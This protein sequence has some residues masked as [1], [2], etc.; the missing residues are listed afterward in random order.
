MQIIL[1]D[2]SELPNEELTAVK[3]P[4]LSRQF[5]S[6]KIYSHYRGFRVSAALCHRC[7]PQLLFWHVLKHKDSYLLAPS[8]DP[9][10]ETSLEP[11]LE[12]GTSG[13]RIWADMFEDWL[14]RGVRR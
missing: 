5:C 3:T 2:Y 9:T 1:N 6:H 7:H 8:M 11:T 14:R 4:Y 12:S 13:S 10:R